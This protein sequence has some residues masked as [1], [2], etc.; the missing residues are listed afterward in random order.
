MADDKVYKLIEI[1]G[2]SPSSID[3]AMKNAVARASQTLRGIDWVELGEVRGL[4][5]DGKLSEFQTKLRV[6][7]RLMDEGELKA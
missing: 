1:V 7:F 2:T 5:K 4:V 3:D 6:G